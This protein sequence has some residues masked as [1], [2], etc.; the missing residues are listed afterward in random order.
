MFT[1]PAAS[2]VAT[3]G[4]EMSGRIAG[5]LNAGDLNEKANRRRWPV[6]R[7]KLPGGIEQPTRCGH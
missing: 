2:I 1:R 4:L 6:R 3:L 7:D 5:G